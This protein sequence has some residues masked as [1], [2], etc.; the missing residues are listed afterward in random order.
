MNGVYVLL[1]V[2]RARP[3]NHEANA[4]VVSCLCAH[5]AALF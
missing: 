1:L 5:A 3:D 4:P 2:L